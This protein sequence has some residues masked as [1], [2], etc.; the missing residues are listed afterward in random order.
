MNKINNNNKLGNLM[1]EIISG[2]AR[3]NHRVYIYC[4]YYIRDQF[5]PVFYTSTRKDKTGRMLDP[6][7]LACKLN[8]FIDQDKLD[9]YLTDKVS[10]S[11]IQIRDIFQTRYRDKVKRNRSQA[12]D[13]TEQIVNALSNKAFTRLELFYGLLCATLKD[14]RPLR[15]RN[16]CGY[17]T[18]PWKKVKVYN[19]IA[20]QVKFK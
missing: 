10:Y 7:D 14:Y 2:S 16:A 19:K 18:D 1:F 5:I 20:K 9:Q 4:G 6:I 12:L 13:L 17:I 3:Y 15:Y 11:D 8:E